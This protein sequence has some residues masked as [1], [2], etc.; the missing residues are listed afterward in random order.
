MQV[1]FGEAVPRNEL[2]TEVIRHASFFHA[3]NPYFAEH[4]A[5][6]GFNQN[7]ITRGGMV[8]LVQRDL[9]QIKQ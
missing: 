2:A 7:Y 6:A 5:L 1:V 3:G 4:V 9:K 8:R